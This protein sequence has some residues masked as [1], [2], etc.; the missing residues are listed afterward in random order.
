MWTKSTSRRCCS[1]LPEKIISAYISS[2]KRIKHESETAAILIDIKKPNLSLQLF[3]KYVEHRCG[4]LFS[5][6]ETQTSKLGIHNSFTV[7]K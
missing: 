4:V 5:S 7:Y 3:E 2:V 6:G 1:S